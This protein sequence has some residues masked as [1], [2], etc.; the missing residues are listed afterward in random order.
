[1]F[2]NVRDVG[3]LERGE[4]G[5]MLVNRGEME[6]RTGMERGLCV[7]PGGAAAVENLG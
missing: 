1:M 3:S 4:E 6:A 5:F 2:W 7:S